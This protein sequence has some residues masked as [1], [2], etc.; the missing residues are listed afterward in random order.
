M[1]NSWPISN[2]VPSNVD[3]LRLVCLYFNK[4]LPLPTFFEWKD[5]MQNN[6]NNKLKYFVQYNLC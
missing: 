3:I 2:Y 4:T 1:S 5:T 6:Y